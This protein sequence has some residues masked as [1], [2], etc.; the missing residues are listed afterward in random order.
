MSEVQYELI[1]EDIFNARVCSTGT[2]DEALEWLRVHHPA[3]TFNNWSKKEAENCAPVACSNDAT[4]K[5]YM[6]WC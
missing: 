6:F 5:H 2:W 4:K 3:G 1:Y